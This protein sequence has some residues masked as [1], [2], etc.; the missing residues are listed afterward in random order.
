[1]NAALPTRQADARERMIAIAIGIGIIT[2]MA[3]LALWL[4]PSGPG[5]AKRDR[6]IQEI[7][8]VT[9]PPP[10]PPPTPEEKIMEEEPEIVEPKDVPQEAQKSEKMDEPAETP[11]DAPPSPSQEPAGLDRPADAGSDSFRLAAGGGGG[12]FG[13]GGGGGGGGGNADGW[14][15]QVERH[16]QR[17]LMRDA[18]TRAATGSVR[19]SVNIDN[20]GRFTSASLRSSTGDADLDRAIRDILLRLPPIGRARPNTVAAATNATINMRR[21][22]D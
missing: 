1:M 21:T 12:L 2:I 22:Q 18:R 4:W 8:V 13:R 20:S 5:D 19:V 11:S 16:I 14:G 9:P 3:L 17:A 15:R 6:V 10:P 7:T